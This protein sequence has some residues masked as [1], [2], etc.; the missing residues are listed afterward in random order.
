MKKGKLIVIILL[1]A[2]VLAGVGFMMNRPEPEEAVVEDV[3]PVVTAEDPIVKDIITYTTLIGTIEPQNVVNVLPKM[4]GEAL[5][6]H[7]AVGDRVEEGQVLI[8]IHSDALTALKIQ[9]DGALVTMNDANTALSRTQAL[10]STGSVSQQALEQA[11]SAARGAKLQYD[12]A[13]N[14][15]DLQVGYTTVTAPISGVIESK[16]VD[17]HDM[18]SPAA[19][20]CVISGQEQNTVVFGA[21]EKVMKNMSVGMEISLEKMGTEYKGNITEIGSMV[22]PATGL[23]SIKA[24]VEDG[25]ALTNGSKVKVS[26]VMN[27]SQQVITIPLDSVFYNNGSPF[28]YCY[29]DGRALKIDFEGGIYDGERMEVI[30][31]ITAEDQVITSWSNELTDQA[32]VL[33]RTSEQPTETSSE[34]GN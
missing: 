5:E 10:Y 17:V 11:Q 6:V 1:V 21:S 8:N 33:L 14:S 19:P 34:S 28:V 32:E 16:S 30:S 18:V 29:S 3:R 7:F 2:A 22:N 9:V 27:Q 15:Y 26:A 23:Y 13:K 12:A 4:N 31:G 25:D 20:I 24:I